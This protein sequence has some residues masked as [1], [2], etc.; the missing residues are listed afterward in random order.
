MEPEIDSPAH[1]KGTTVNN[2]SIIV[3]PHDLDEDNALT[4]FHHVIADNHPGT[5]VVCSS[6]FDSVSTAHNPVDIV[7]TGDGY[8]STNWYTSILRLDDS[9]LEQGP[10]E[11][12]KTVMGAVEQHVYSLVHVPLRGVAP[13]RDTLLVLGPGEGATVKSE[14]RYAD[15][16]ER[17]KFNV[18][19]TDNA[20]GI[21]DGVFSDTVATWVAPSAAARCVAAYVRQMVQKG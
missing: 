6:Y 20:T 14:F 9:L 11:V 19:V 1:T 12:L 8:V 10:D 2:T 3:T 17:V 7:V 5:R 18:E 4:T 13:G 16:G 21:T 15:D